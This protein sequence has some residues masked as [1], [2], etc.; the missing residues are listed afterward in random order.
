M[1]PAAVKPR[2]HVRWTICAL[3]FGAATVNYLDRQV[4]S[5]LKGTLSHELGWNEL[6]YGNLVTAFQGAYALGMLLMGRLMDSLGTRRGFSLAVGF[7]SLAAMAHGLATSTLGFAGARFALGLGEAGM[8]PGAVK[9]I[10]EWFPKR[11]RALATGIFNSGTNVGAILC[12]IVVPAVVTVWGYRA[13]FVVTGGAGML[14]LV[15]WLLLY[16]PPA[17]HPKLTHDERAYIESEPPARGAH[18][19]WRELWPHR[20]AWAFAGAKFLTDPFWW[21]YLF[22]IPDFLQKTYGLKLLQVGPP[23]VVIYLMSDFGSVAGGYLS[24]RWL[25]RGASVNRARKYAML[26]C[27][28]GVVPI[29]L[30]TRV[31]SLW[32][33]VLLVGLATAAH[34]GF[35][36]N[37]FTLSSDLF[38]AR[39]VGS[40]VG[41]GGMA[42][43]LGGML[44]AQVASHV[45]LWTGN[46]TWLF[47]AASS[48]Y[49]AA[50]V[51]I[52]ALS[53]ELKPATLTNTE[54]ALK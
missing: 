31:N 50:V 15:A 14:W 38:P 47:A 21:L 45:L 13:A 16:K 36:A 18:L 27:A 41:F 46:Y 6:D 52:H 26:V 17:E 37:L 4:L 25:A 10:A 23:L 22:W 20:Q 7:W 2:G 33:A 30:A 29:L 9:T 48:A 39:A 12:P 24:S 40:V 49:F 34:Q 54:E 42:G 19:R 35:S 51:W 44:L 5:V 3:L 28:L 1:R 53:P 32:S 8:F 11:E 43:A